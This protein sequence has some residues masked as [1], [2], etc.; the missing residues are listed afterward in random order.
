MVFLM[1][2]WFKI[3]NLWIG[4]YNNFRYLI[5]I[6]FL[7]IAVLLY[8]F[9]LPRQNSSIQN[10]SHN[11]V[12]IPGGKYFMGSDKPNS[13]NNE[14][15]VHEVIVDSFFMDKY[16]VTNNQ[17]LQFVKETGYI[18]TAEKIINWSDMR[19]QLPP[20]TPKPPDSLLQP[21]SL[22]FKESKY[23]IPLNDES[24]WW[25]WKRGASW[26]HPLGKNSS[27]KKIMDHPVVHISW[28][29]AV[30]YAQ[31]AGKRLPTEA[32]WEWAARGKKT[33]AIYPWGN[34]SINEKPMKA[35][36]WQGHFP[37]K[38][39][40]QD[41]YHL[42]APVGSFIS[43]EYGLF[44]MSGN[45][46]EWCSDFYHVNSY[47]YDKEKGICINPKGPKTS[48]DPSEPFAIKKILRGGS[49]LCNDSYCSGYRV[50]RRMSS[51]KDTGLMHTGFRCVKDIS[52]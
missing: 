42:T 26:Q 44:D 15:P 47:S 12:L 39:T 37:Y 38:N 23:P 21:G 40:E 36:F 19:N 48:Y 9:P 49:F 3:T 1:E 33:D 7:I 51:S 6:G 43:N 18:T 35:N 28:D 20:G 46:W 13:Y 27:I 50:S 2:V 11:M 34:E 4:M 32:E 17:F 52:G 8:K 31:W 45:V 41:G 29:D 14:M 10:Y 22:V 30:A 24:G 16:E 25:E 5:V